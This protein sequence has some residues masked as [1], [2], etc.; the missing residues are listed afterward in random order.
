[1]TTDKKWYTV[2]TVAEHINE[3]KWRIVDQSADNVLNPIDVGQ[4]EAERNAKLCAAAPEMIQ[5]IGIM[6][7]AIR[8]PSG[9]IKQELE[10]DVMNKCEQLLKQLTT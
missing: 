8:M 7:G 10:I 4:Q 3:E 1:M 9:A 5:L 2:R 6:Y